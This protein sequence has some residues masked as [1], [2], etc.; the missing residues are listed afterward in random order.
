MLLNVRVGIFFGVGLL[1]S[2]F[3]GASYSAGLEE[4]VVTG[5]PLSKEA[6]QVN[7]MA[8]KVNRS[9][10]TRKGGS[11]LSDS[12]ADIPGVTSSGFASGASRPVIR[13]FDANRVRILENGVGSF[14]VSDI[15]PDHGVPVDPLSTQSVEVVHGAATLR[16]GS[17]AIGGVVNA[18]NNR[19]PLTLP[20]QTMQGQLNASYASNAHTWQGA[21]LADGRIGQI[22]VHADA[23]SRQADDYAFRGG[24]QGNSYFKGG[25]FSLGGAYFFNRNQSRLG[26]TAIHYDSQYGIP[27]DDTYIDVRQD[28][29][30]LASDLAM[31][32]DLF[33]TITFNAGYADYTHSEIDPE[34]G[35]RLATFNDEEWDVRGEGILDAVGPFSAAAVGLQLQSRD[36]AALGEAKTYL[37]P[38]QA[39]SVAGF[40]FAEIA[41]SP[42]LKWQFGARLE[43]VRAQGIPLSDVPAQLDFNLVSAS[44]GLLADAA[45]K[46]KLGVNLSSTA[47]APAQ[48]ELFARGPHDGPATYES[49]DWTLKPE[50]A[51]SLEGILRLRQDR[52]HLDMAL[53]LSS[54]DHFI[55]GQLTGRTCDE[56]GRCVVG[57]SEELKELFY[58]Q[59]DATFYGF[60]A[61]S[62]LAILTAGTGS[63]SLGLLADYVRATFDRGGD[64]VPRLPPYRVGGGVFWES[65]TLEIG[66]Q[67]KYSAKQDNVADTEGPTEA[68]SSVDAYV[69]WHF[70]ASGQ[71]FEVSLVGRN[72]TDSEQRNAVAFNKDE[73]VMPGRDIRLMVQLDF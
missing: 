58:A 5:S 11:S 70:A 34:S 38:T 14:D 27:G 47:R 7:G 13:G 50:R 73:V 16:Y 52:L 30:L 42:T 41:H 9:E 67:L 28:K 63:L 69:T 32:N 43:R 44:I 39:H 72:L 65:N 66:A 49:G 35:D 3:A 31:E 24:V 37:Q 48:T 29:I 54:F 19:I 12:L 26:G 56:E 10:I 36:F 18:V 51:N 2:V 46:V 8:G 20:E 71:A 17:Q 15:G 4:I 64:Y 53:W 23:F 60:E 45:D 25:G 33:T 59:R 40:G 57:D 21:A 1:L 22:A 55:Y 68:F 62:T 6:D 61:K